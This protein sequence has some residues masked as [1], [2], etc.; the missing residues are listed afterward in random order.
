MVRASSENEQLLTVGASSARMECLVRHMSDAWFNH[1][2]SMRPFVTTCDSQGIFRRRSPQPGFVF[3]RRPLY[4]FFSGIVI[5]TLGSCKDETLGFW[6]SLQ[7]ISI[8]Q[9]DNASHSMPSPRLLFLSFSSVTV[10]LL[11]RQLG[12][13]ISMREK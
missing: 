8:H 12:G 2:T 3:Q 1:S 10:L 13:Q 6:T 4:A 7:A 5:H 11:A 9:P